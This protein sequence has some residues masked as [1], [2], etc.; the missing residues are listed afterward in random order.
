VGPGGVFCDQ[1]HTA[2]RFRDSV[3]EP[4][5]WSLEM[6]AAW[7]AGD[8]K[9]DVDHARDR[10]HA[11]IEGREPVIELTEEEQQELLAVIRAR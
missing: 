10:Y 3:W 7:E 6:L 2:A 5:I 4:D 11:L 1:P 8:R 9:I